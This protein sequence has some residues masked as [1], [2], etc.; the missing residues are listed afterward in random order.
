[1]YVLSRDD[2]RTL[3]R[4]AGSLV[5]DLA[6]TRTPQARAKR[7]PLK[8]FGLPLGETF[9]A[10]SVRQLSDVRIGQLGE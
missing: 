9:G 4:F 10:Q 7:V 1:M 3:E 2:N 8:I 5:L 6:F